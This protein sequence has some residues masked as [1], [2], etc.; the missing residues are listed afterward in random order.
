MNNRF[1]LLFSNFHSIEN[2]KRSFKQF[3][4]TSFN[5][6]KKR[7]SKTDIFSPLGIQ[8]EILY[9]K[10][11]I[12][13]VHGLSSHIYHYSSCQRNWPLW[14]RRLY[15]W[16]I[17][18]HSILFSTLSLS[19]V[20]MFFLFSSSSNQ[21]KHTANLCGAQ[22]KRFMCIILSLLFACTWIGWHIWGILR[23]IFEQ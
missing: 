6:M 8:L 7:N 2:Q 21:S 11:A 14:N 1:I 19:L 4:E 16:P 18:S 17:S 9:S 23:N 5:L 13:Q 15:A 3:S 22:S 20:R 10:S 12:C